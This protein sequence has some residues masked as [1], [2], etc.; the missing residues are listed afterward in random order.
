MKTLSPR[1]TLAMIEDSQPPRIQ[2]HMSRS[3]VPAD[4]GLLGVS[5]YL[6]L[7]EYQR[8]QKPPW[9]LRTGIA[10]SPANKQ[11]VNRH[12]VTDEAFSDFFAI[13]TQEEQ[14]MQRKSSSKQQ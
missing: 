12:D 13:I 9:P 7:T 2:V 1:K 3:T 14:G 6:V 10:Q 4:T 8:K 11:G 5:P